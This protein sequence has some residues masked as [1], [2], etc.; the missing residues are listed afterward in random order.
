VRGG[1]TMFST[2]GKSDV[3]FLIVCNVCTCGVFVVNATIACEK[4][5]AYRGD[6]FEY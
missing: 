6:L 5:T 1:R 2:L 3:S 4:E